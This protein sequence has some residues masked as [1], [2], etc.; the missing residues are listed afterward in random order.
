MLFRSGENG[1]R[2]DDETTT[3]HSP[4]GKKVRKR[5]SIGFGDSSDEGKSPVAQGDCA[6]AT[7]WSI[8]TPQHV[9]L[10]DTEGAHNRRRKARSL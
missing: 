2:I 6:V 9:V 4:S 3:A 10:T 7:G 5:I 1:D 8:V